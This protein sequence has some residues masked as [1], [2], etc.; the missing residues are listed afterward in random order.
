MFYC[1]VHLD[2]IIRTIAYLISSISVFAT[3][4]MGSDLKPG[5]GDGF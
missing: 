5:R 3:G 4:P 2:L 1:N